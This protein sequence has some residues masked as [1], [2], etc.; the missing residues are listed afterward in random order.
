MTRLALRV[1]AVD[2]GF[3]QWHGYLWRLEPMM[4]QH[5]HQVAEVLTAIVGDGQAANSQK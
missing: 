1:V 5:H 4:H 2:V 3:D